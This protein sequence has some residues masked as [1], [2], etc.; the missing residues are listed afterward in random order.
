[1]TVTY[2]VC[3]KALLLH[4]NYIMPIINHYTLDTFLDCERNLDKMQL[5]AACVYIAVHFRDHTSRIT[6]GG[7]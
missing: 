7:V 2:V 4:Y 6:A 5:I 1:M 3:V